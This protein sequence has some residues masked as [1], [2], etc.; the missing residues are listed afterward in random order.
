MSQTGLALKTVKN[1]RWLKIWLG[2]K[3]ATGFDKSAAAGFQS[4]DD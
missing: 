3:A 2:V 1:A 4:D